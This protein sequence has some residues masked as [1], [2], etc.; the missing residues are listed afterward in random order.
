MSVLIGGAISVI[1]GII[2]LIEWR[3]EFGIILKGTV[4]LILLLGGV[5]VLYVGYDELQEKLREEKQ[6]QE[7]K[8]EKARGEIEMIKAR[9]ELY[10][11]E[12]ER[13]KEETREREKI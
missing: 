1:L 2:G 11:E 13:L 3:H 6:R 8:L 7:E 12:L 5:L 10:R 4:P 9:A